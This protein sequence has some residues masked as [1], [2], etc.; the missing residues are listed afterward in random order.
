MFIKRNNIFFSYYLKSY[1]HEFNDTITNINL[2]RSQILATVLF[3][4]NALLLVLDLLIYKPMRSVI[5]AYSYLY[6]LHLIVMPFLIVF[7]GLGIFIKKQNNPVCKKVFI[8]SLIFITM[9]WC[10]FMGINSMYITGGISA[11]II[12]MFSFAT[13]FLISPLKTFFIYLVSLVFFIIWINIEC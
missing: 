1:K 8:Y 4:V 5:P 9:L 13:C 12:C 10:G 6:Y 7:L 11:Y 3:L 2:K